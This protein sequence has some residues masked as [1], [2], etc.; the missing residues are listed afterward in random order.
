[1][2]HELPEPQRIDFA[3][4]CAPALEAVLSAYPKYITVAELPTETDAQRLDIA[5]ALVEA[6]AV[7]VR[8]SVNEVVTTT[9]G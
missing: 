5:Q 7:L 4:E 3:L 2:Y 8:Q 9:S 6:R 1:M